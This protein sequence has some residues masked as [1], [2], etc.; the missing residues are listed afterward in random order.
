MEI[1]QLLLALNQINLTIA[2]NQIMFKKRNQESVLLPMGYTNLGY[3][4]WL[5]SGSSKLFFMGGSTANLN[6]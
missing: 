4:Q 6:Y 5:P 2:N 1:I 3:D